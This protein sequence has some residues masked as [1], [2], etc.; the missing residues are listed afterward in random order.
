MVPSV[1]ITTWAALMNLLLDTCAL[2]FLAEKNLIDETA[3][4]ELEIAGNKNSI[5][6]SPI[7]AWEIGRL[8]ASRRIP[9]SME[10]LRFFKLFASSPGINLCELTLEIMVGS[11][12]L[13]G[14]P[15]KDPMDRALI[16]TARHFDYTL[17]TR[18]RAILIYGQQ[19][20]VKTLAC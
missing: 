16:E 18:D 2:L 15:H 1:V 8:S 10:P 11:S 14:Q 5:F 13:P 3:R 20:H 17:V 12:Y 19:G 7:S 9:M 4:H 6:V